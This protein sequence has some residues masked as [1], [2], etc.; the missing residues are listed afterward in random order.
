NDDTCLADFSVCPSCQNGIVDAGEECDPVEPCRGLAADEHNCDG[1]G[2]PILSQ[3]SCA[4]IEVLAS[5]LDKAA[6]TRGTV[7]QNNCGEGCRY[8]RR[9]CNFC[10]DGVLDPEHDDVGLDGAFFLRSAERCEVGI[11]T[12]YVAERCADW[13]G[14]SS[15][16]SLVSC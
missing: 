6:Y 10:G 14:A 15:P 3:K 8:S 4:E 2:P 7:N 1:E 5:S 16:D 11:L 12:D 9:E 13:C